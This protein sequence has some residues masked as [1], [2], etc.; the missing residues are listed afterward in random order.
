MREY[1]EEIA[2]DEKDLLDSTSLRK[3]LPR[4]EEFAV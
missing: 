2:R 3:K 4:L 1:A